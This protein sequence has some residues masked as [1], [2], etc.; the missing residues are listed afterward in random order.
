MVICIYIFIDRIYNKKYI[1]PKKLLLGIRPRYVTFPM[2]RYEGPRA[3]RRV[4]AH[5]V[6]ERCVKQVQLCSV[7]LGL[8]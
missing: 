2:N 3:L 1:E 4:G 6:V 7:V 5:L 8:R